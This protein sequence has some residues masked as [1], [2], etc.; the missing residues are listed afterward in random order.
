MKR[1]LSIA[2]GAIM[3]TSAAALAGCGERGNSSAGEQTLVYENG[4]QYVG[5]VK[6]G[7]ANGVGKLTDLAGNVWEGTF[8]DDL[9]QG[10]GK[11]SGFDFVEYTGEFKDSQFD[12]LGYIVYPNGDEYWG[13]FEES[14]K[15]G[16]GKMVFAESGCVYEGA[17]EE[18]NM[19]GFGWMTWSAGDVYWGNWRGG[20]PQ[21]FGC[22]VFFDSAF[23]VKGDYQTYNIYSGRMSA[24]Q[25][26]GWGMMYYGES[27]GLYLGEWKQG[28]RD[29]TQGVYYFEEGAEWIKFVGN[30]SAQD[31]QGWIWGE[32]TMYYTDGTIVEG[33]FHGTDLVEKASVTTGAPMERV[34]PFSLLLADESLA[35]GLQILEKR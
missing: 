10:Y 31:N 3:L 17:W 23:S 32:G 13:Q 22:K 7:K 28:V 14:K 1:I 30:F 24:N 21:G 29:D 35:S 12:G 33:V 11:Y 15:I 16:V 19:S 2:L 26:E 18:D 4:S 5:E 34:D 27:G 9:L 20:V 25:M 6:N 8:A